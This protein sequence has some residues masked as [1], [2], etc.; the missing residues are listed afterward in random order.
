M[1]PTRTQDSSEASYTFSLLAA[2]FLK[3]VLALSPKSEITPCGSGNLRL[4]KK[5]AVAEWLK[6]E[7]VCWD[8]FLFLLE[9]ACSSS[10]LPGRQGGAALVS[11][12]WEQGGRQVCPINRSASYCLP[13]FIQPQY[14]PPHPG[15]HT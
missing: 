15:A 1:G 10:C 4:E 14:T 13:A 7:Q 5:E 12:L 9:G 6:S 2:L 8:S 11:T 3:S